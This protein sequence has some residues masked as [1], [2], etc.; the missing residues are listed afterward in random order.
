MGVGGIFNFWG[1]IDGGFLTANGTAAAGIDYR[2]D[3]CS[4]T[5]CLVNLKAARQSC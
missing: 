4:Q 2:F 1:L 3:S 5:V